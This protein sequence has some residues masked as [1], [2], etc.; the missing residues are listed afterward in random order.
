MQSALEKATNNDFQYS[1]QSIIE[2]CGNDLQD[3]EF[4]LQAHPHPISGAVDFQQQRS[5]ILRFHIQRRK[6]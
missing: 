1:F 4:C 2:T 3:D 5:E 6:A